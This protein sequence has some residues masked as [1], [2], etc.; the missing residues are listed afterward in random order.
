MLAPGI[1]FPLLSFNFPRITVCEYSCE[2]ITKPAT[3]AIDFLINPKF[4]HKRKVVCII[5]QIKKE[6]ADPGKDRPLKHSINTLSK[7]TNF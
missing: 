2:A 1:G 6:K 3:T 4:H 5:N 7:K